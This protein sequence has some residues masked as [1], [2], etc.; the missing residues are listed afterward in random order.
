[1]AAQ[2]QI[3]GPHREQT[4]RA[5]RRPALVAREPVIHC[6]RALGQIPTIWDRGEWKVE[7]PRLTAN[8]G[9][10]DWKITEDE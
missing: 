7:V 4:Q 8:W 3:R 6:C 10:A 9:Q 2:L 5:R 1:M